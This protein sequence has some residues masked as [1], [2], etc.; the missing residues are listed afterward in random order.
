MSRLLPLWRRV[1]RFTLAHRRGAAA[2]LA[3][4]AVLLV[5]R[6]LTVPPAATQALLV[7]TRDLPS[8]TVLAPGDLTLAPFSLGSV[9][10]GA[11][12]PEVV[13]IGRVLAGP[14]GQGEA[15]THVRLVGDGLLGG[16]PGRAVTPVRISDAGT[17]PLLTAG[18]RIDLLGADPATGLVR[19]LASGAE[20][21]AVPTV[22]TASPGS[23]GLLLVAVAP[24]EAD[25]I[26]AASVSAY[27][28]W[29][30]A[31]G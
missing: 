8:G 2:L 26:A 16:Y 14:L 3:G 30:L 17:L 1:R 31:E 25:R 7:A 29:V 28:S 12:S 9:P 21:V 20:V 6:A 13:P 24:D 19:T 15:L 4:L 18:M 23:G 22:G 5:V 27:I 11:V 10:P